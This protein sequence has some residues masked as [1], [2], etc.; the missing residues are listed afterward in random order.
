MEAA[1]CGVACLTMVLA[2]YG[3][4][5][6]L[7]DVRQVCGTSRDGNSAADLLRG[8][9]HYHLTGRGLK[10]SLDRLR[11][12]PLPVVLHWDMNHFVVLEGTTASGLS[13][14]D[15]ASGRRSISWQAA[16]RLFSGVVLAFD[17]GAG[18]LT[19]APSSVSYGRY[20]AALGRSWPTVAFILIANLVGQVLALAF[21]AANQVLIDHVILPN[22]REWLL[23]VLALMLL[24]SAGQVLLV[25][26][27]G[28]SQ[29]YL[30]GTLSVDL[31]CELGRRI[32]R[33]PLPYLESRSHGDLLGRLQLQAELQGLVARAAQGA[34]DLLA[35]VL[36]GTLMLAYDW[37]LG[38][39]AL[40]LLM[41]RLVVIRYARSAT[42]QRVAAEVAARAREQSA[43]VEATSCPELV[44]GLAL[45]SRLLA[46][47]E[48][49]VNERVG[50]SVSAQRLQQLIAVGLSTFSALMS[51]L[52]LGFGG[53]RVIAGQMT[54]GVFAGFL[55][56]QAL[57]QTPLSSLLGLL[58]SWLSFRG[59]LSRSDEL[60]SAP[61]CREGQ[62][63]HPP[64]DGR[65][66]ARNLGFRYGTGGKW[67]LRGINF[68]IQPGEHVA[69][70]GPS[71]QGKSTLGKL[72]TG[73]LEP[74]EGEVLLDGIPVAHYDRSALSR[75]MG[76]VLQEPL[77]LEGTL[78][79]ALALRIPDA[80]EADLMQAA[81]QACFSEVIGRIPGGLEA[82]VAAQG[83][84]L[85]GGERQRLALAQALV[86]NPK[87]LLL[88]EAT[89]A[90]DPHTERRVLATLA[91]LPATVIS[92]AHRPE[93]INC[94]RRVL[95]VSE[96]R[97]CELEAL[98]YSE[99]AR[100]QR[101]W[102]GT[103]S[104]RAPSEQS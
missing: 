83:S 26:L 56:I 49:H 47:Y 85:S 3:H 84:N 16:D 68:T 32:L 97:V 94:A 71:G 29:A 34:F 61:V 14:I 73:L 54:V 37:Q 64:R 87:L 77:I 50:A 21:P 36:M 15:P 53:L 48:R 51:A 39:L 6:P 74:S 1:E 70:I 19:R 28:T 41:A 25:K 55:A 66:E 88:D 69:I 12:L 101:T 92:A 13:I 7:S 45:E 63:A 33:L 93:V 11:S 75:E 86:G 57:V 40:C 38:V 103:E 43:I 27:Q 96:T 10:R 81:E 4:H 104:R 8:A 9:G 17:P 52:I 67:V 98:E 102:A 46:R 20:L 35:V 24:G 62:Y 58:E 100:S 31:S 30:H 18:F 44:K 79:E 2:H 60:L 82:R 22:R 95:S 90:L 42:S 65:L 76:V 78:R 99:A 5:A 72:L 91:R 23:P 80:S 89:C 59:A